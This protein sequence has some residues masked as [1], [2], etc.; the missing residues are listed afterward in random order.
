MKVSIPGHKW[1]NMNGSHGSPRA[2]QAVMDD[3]KKRG[4]VAIQATRPEPV[5]TPVEIVAYV[6]RTTNASSDAHNVT[7]SIKACIDAAV[8]C[9]V[10]PDDNDAHVVQLVIRRGPNAARPTIDL[11]IRPAR[12]AS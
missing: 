10:I 11:E 2:H 1:A 3:W 8:A 4:I 7:P 6:R 9:G 12:S 5:P